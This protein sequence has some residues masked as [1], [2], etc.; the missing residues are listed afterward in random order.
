MFITGIRTSVVT[1]E[2]CEA[3]VG[4]QG[5]PSPHINGQNCTW[6]WNNFELLS[7]RVHSSRDSTMLC[8]SCHSGWH[9][10]VTA[11]SSKD[12]VVIL[13][14]S[15]HANKTNAVIWTKPMHSRWC[16]HILVGT[17]KVATLSQVQKCCYNWSHS[18]E[19]AVI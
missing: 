17:R 6:L 14:N 18:G 9:D 8:I 16:K 13:K 19:S 10:L 7:G 12:S 3:M 5:D 1:G 4:R 15:G 11:E 2:D